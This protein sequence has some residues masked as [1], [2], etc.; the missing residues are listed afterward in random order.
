MPPIQPLPM[1]SPAGGPILREPFPTSAP[2][3]NL[4]K[5]SSGP[6]CSPH[7][8]EELR[9][10]GDLER[11][12]L[13][14]PAR[15]G[16]IA[17]VNPTKA[18]DREFSSSFLASEPLRDLILMQDPT[19][20]FE[21]WV[22]QS[23]IKKAIHQQNRLAEQSEDSALNPRLDDTLRRAVDLASEKGASSWLTSLPLSEFGFTLHKGAFRDALALRYGWLPSNSPTHCDCGSLFTVDHCLSC[24]KGGFPTLRH[25]EIRDLTAR[26]LTEVSH[27]VRVEPNLQPIT[28]EVFSRATSN[29]QEGARLDVVASGFWGGR[30]ERTFLDVRVFNPHAQSNRNIPRRLATASMKT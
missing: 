26:L 18:S 6:S 19:Y 2:S 24:C 7:L 3:C 14:L 1:D 9:L 10:H 8:Q 22:K 20:S 29:T 15:L 28:G 5:P 21:T 25:N 16:G 23:S 12:L 4:L 30:Y 11:D 17:L 27:E 13:A